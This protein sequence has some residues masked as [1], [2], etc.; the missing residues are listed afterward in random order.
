MR[1]SG[2][3]RG[4]RFFLILSISAWTASTA[5]QPDSPDEQTEIIEL[6]IEPERAARALEWQPWA[7]TVPIAALTLG[8]EL[9]LEPSNARWASAGLVDESFEPW[10]R[11]SE[12]GRARARTASD[13]FM[14][15]M[16]AAPVADIALWQTSDGQSGADAYR[17][18]SSAALAFSI[19]AFFVTTT[20]NIAR[21]ARP[22][23]G[24]C[25]EDADARG[26]CDS[27]SRYRG[28]ISGHTSVA[29]TGASLLCAFSRLRGQPAGGRAECLV[30]LLAASITGA[31]RI[32]G[33]QHYFSDVLAGAVS[34]FL[35]G[36]IVPVFV[37]PRDL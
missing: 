35:A 16:A 31:L 7:A 22:Y 17:L 12:D 29:F 27:S 14:A 23:D 28:F 18:L 36:F 25:R 3:S 32:V 34:G 10:V 37:Y 20:K 33:E 9:A 13:V 6:D 21:R 1:A 26:A 24:R 11:A 8:L 2:N 4:V 15:A 19:Q 30:G 5:A